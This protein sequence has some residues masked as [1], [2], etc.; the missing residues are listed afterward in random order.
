MYKNEGV[1]CCYVGILAE[2]R[3]RYVQ[4]LFLDLKR[5]FSKPKWGTLQV[6]LGKS[7]IIADFLSS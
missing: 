2:E 6:S 7:F 5:D 1:L 4:Q 3:H